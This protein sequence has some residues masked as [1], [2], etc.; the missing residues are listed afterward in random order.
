MKLRAVV[1]RLA[2]VIPAGCLVLLG[3]CDRCFGV[4]ACGDS[5]PFVAVEGRVVTSESGIGVSGAAVELLVITNSARDSARTETNAEGLY[6]LRLDVEDDPSTRLSLRVK[7]TGKPGYLV[8]TLPCPVYRRRGETCVLFPIAELPTFPTFYF[9]YRNDPAR[10]VAGAAVRFVRT[11]GTQVIGPL[12]ANEF[13]G[14]TTPEGFVALFTVGMFATTLE[15]LVGRLS[16]E[17]PA[18]YGTSVRESYEVKPNF[19]F[20]RTEVLQAVG[21]GLGYLFTFED[22]ATHAPVPDVT[23]SFDRTSGISIKPEHFKVVGN[24]EGRAAFELYPA[25][26]GLVVGDLTLRRTT[27]STPTVFTGFTLQTFDADTSIVLARYRVGKTGVF[28][29]IVPSP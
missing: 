11:G 1:T 6:S 16:V 22:S 14:T 5:P 26:P 25:Q 17:L 21:P 10:P 8:D 4:Q 19:W 13:E 7:P 9:R 3:A 2:T 12:S 15:P 23:M 24:S 29:P 27:T 28:Y 18:P 20:G